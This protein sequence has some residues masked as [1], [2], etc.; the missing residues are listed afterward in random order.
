MFV[1]LGCALF[2]LQLV[3]E[4]Q[5]EVLKERRPLQ[6]L[7]SSEILK[8]SKLFVST[9]SALFL[10]PLRTTPFNLFHRVLNDD[11][12]DASTLLSTGF[13]EVQ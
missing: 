13:T 12:S 7:V 6:K 4:G 8:S 2:P 5:G 9:G 3:G 11:V 10:S 1:L